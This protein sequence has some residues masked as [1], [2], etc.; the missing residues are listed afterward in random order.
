MGGAEEWPQKGTKRHKKKRGNILN[1]MVGF[2]FC[3]FLCLFVAILLASLVVPSVFSI[4][5]P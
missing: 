3:A 4:N 2:V 1:T 5:N